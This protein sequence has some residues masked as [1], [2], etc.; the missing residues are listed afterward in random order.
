VKIVFATRNRDK[1]REIERI[2][3]GLSVEIIDS[4]EFP[5][6]PETIE[7]GETCVANALKKAREV[8]HF[9]DLPALADDSGLFVEALDGQPGVYSSR[10]AGPGCTYNDNNDKLLKEMADIP[11]E[12]RNAYFLCVAALVLPNGLEITREGRLNGAI[13]I[14]KRGGSGFG[15]DPVFQ[16]PDGRTIAEIDTSEKNRISHRAKAFG[17]IRQAISDLL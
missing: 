11:S 7:D 9:T 1:I 14:S 5:N 6:M 3:D 4:M 2:L 15:Y 8:S 17:A 13:A 12:E 16:L 10:Y